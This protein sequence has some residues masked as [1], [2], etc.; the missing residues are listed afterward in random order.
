MLTIRNPVP[1]VEETRIRLG[2]SKRRVKQ[3][4][5]IMASPVSSRKRG[6]L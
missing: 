1:T 6:N 4:R 2:M 5:K 3:I